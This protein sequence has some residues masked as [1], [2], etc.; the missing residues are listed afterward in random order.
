MDT[1]YWGTKSASGQAM[2]QTGTGKVKSIK[3]MDSEVFQWEYINHVSMV[4]GKSAEFPD[5]YMPRCEKLKGQRS[6]FK[7]NLTIN[8]YY[9]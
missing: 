9:Y 2:K 5:E 8:A 7:I 1:A 3:F 4:K 6:I